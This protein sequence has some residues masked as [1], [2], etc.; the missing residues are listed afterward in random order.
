MN[1]Y[2]HH[3]HLSLWHS[4]YHLFICLIILTDHSSLTEEYES[5]D[6]SKILRKMRGRISI[7][8]EPSNSAF[9]S[10]DGLDRFLET[11]MSAIGKLRRYC[12]VYGIRKDLSDIGRNLVVFTTPSKGAFYFN[13]EYKGRVLKVVLNVRDLYVM[14]WSGAKGRFEMNM[15]CENRNNFMLDPVTLLHFKKVYR[16]LAPMNKDG[17]SGVQNVLIGLSAWQIGFE[18]MHKSTCENKGLRQAVAT[19]AV[20]LAE[21]A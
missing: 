5:A 21:A 17:V 20:H 12:E 10:L 1:S 2:L 13:V 14:G 16:F 6:F 18:A 19:F 4:L 3:Q 7:E 11:Y 9:I 15:P 8:E